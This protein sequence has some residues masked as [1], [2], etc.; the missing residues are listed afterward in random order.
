[1]QE[2]MDKM[3]GPFLYN[4]DYEEVIAIIY[5]LKFFASNEEERREAERFTDN[6]I[7]II[8]N[9]YR[10]KKLQEIKI[11]PRYYF[12]ETEETTEDKYIKVPCE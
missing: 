6:F 10:M 7:S 12:F 3:Q 1:M 4:I 5:S 2:I 8:Y 11:T 9:N